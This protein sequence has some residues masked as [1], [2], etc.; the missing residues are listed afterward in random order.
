MSSTLGLVADVVP[1]SCVD[2]PGNR[3]VVFTQGCTFNCLA[4]HNPHT[5]ARREVD[6]SRWVDVAELLD[7]LRDALPFISGVTVSGGEATCQWPFVLELFRAI[8]SDPELAHLTT[9]VD[10]N[11]DAEAAV[12]DELAPVMNGAMVDLKALDAELHEMLTGRPNDTVLASIRHLAARGLLHEV[13]L[14]LIPGMNDDA[15]LLRRTAGWLLAAAP[16]T[17]VRLNGF[18][19]AG[20]RLAARAFPESTPEHLQAAA[21]VLADAGIAPALLAPSPPPPSV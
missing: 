8:K 14:L 19:H 13:R 9:L 5:I 12:W 20:T 7:E 15:A 4:C 3:F 6:G 11:G 18:R 1:A 10:T 21:Q 17:P 2:G 16:G